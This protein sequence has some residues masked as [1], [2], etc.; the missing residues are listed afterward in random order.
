MKR[1]RSKTALTLS[2]ANARAFTWIETMLLEMQRGLRDPQRLES[3]EWI[4]LFGAKQSAV[5]NLQKLVQSLATL[6]AS[7]AKKPSAEGDYPEDAAIH[8][9]EMQSLSAWLNDNGA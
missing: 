3:K 8:S 7:R 9:P 1:N 2:R 6:N 5:A 4:R